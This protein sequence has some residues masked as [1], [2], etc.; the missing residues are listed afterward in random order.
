MQLR[1]FDGARLSILA[2]SL[3]AVFVFAALVGDTTQT[4][5]RHKQAHIGEHHLPA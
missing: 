2:L 4:Q 1:N 5:S 3:A